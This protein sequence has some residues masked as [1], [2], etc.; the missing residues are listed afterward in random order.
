MYISEKDMSATQSTQDVYKI[1]LIQRKRTQI[2]FFFFYK[3][4]KNT[5]IKNKKKKIKERPFVPHK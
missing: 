3:K 1:P 4:K 2:F 5:N